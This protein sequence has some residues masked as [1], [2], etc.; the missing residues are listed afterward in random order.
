VRDAIDSALKSPLLN[1][2]DIF[3]AKRILFNISFSQQS[4]ILMEEMDEV[5]EFMARFRSEYEVIWGTAIDNTLE[6]KVKMT[7]LATGFGV[8]NMIDVQEPKPWPDP[9]GEIYYPP[10]QGHVKYYIFPTE[11]LDNDDI[12][13][14]LEEHPTYE[15]DQKMF[16]DCISKAAAPVRQPSPKAQGSFVISFNNNE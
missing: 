8:R 1:N 6:N 9:R 11:E 2:N 5:N 3:T 4:E 10:E 12:I 14:L 13:S 16:K 7:I 15:R